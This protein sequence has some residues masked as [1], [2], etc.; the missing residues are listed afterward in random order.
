MTPERW[1]QVKD[2]FE[3]ATVLDSAQGSAYLDQACAGDPDLRHEVES[4]IASRERAGTQFLQTPAV[5]LLEPIPQDKVG[6]VARAGTRIGVYQL[7][8]EIGHGGMGEVYRARRA[9][10]Q[11]DKEV[12]VKVVRGGRNR[13]ALAERFLHERQIL[14]SLDHANIARLLD[15]GATA[16]GAP[17]LVMEFV[18][19]MPID[20]YCDEN[21]LNITQRLQL[22][23]Q[24]CAAVEYAHRHLVIHRDLKPGNILVTSQGN[25]KLLDFGIA[26]ILDTSASTEAT[27]AHPMTPGYASPEQM[28]GEPITT[29]T[30]IYSLGVV[31][32]HLLTGHSPYGA[33][34]SPAEL[35][36][37]I[38]ETQ[39]ERP[40]VAIL[41][42]FSGQV[43]GGGDETEIT[44]EAISRT[45]EG[46]PTKLQRRLSGDLDNILL[47]ALRKEP[48]RRY[49]SVE[50]FDEDLRRHLEG[51]PVTAR[52]DSWSYRGGKFINRH[53]IAAAA[54][55]VA[56]LAL[57]AGVGLILRAE[58][59]ARL[60]AE[61][62]QIQRSRADQRFNDLRKLSNSLIFEIHDAIQDLPGATPA[63]KL[64]LDRAVEYLDHLANNSNDDPD[65]QR[66]LA[67]GYQRLAV[68]QGNSTES[69]LG[70]ENS[71][72][73][74]DRK[75][76]ALFEAVA[77]AN[78]K[79]IIDQLNVAMGH[80]L[81]SF[82]L[83]MQPEGRHH[84]D[85]AMAISDGLIRIDP[86]NPKVR[87]ERAVE[88]QNLGI[89]QDIAGD[90]AKA[91]ESA[92]TFRDMRA[93]LFRT[94][95]DYPKVRRSVALSTVRLAEQLGLMGRRT[96]ALQEMNNGIG[97]YEQ[98]AKGDPNPDIKRELAISRSKL[99]RIQ[100][101]QGD[102]TAAAESFR[103]AADAINMLAKADPENSLFQY[104]K[105]GIDY[106]QGRALLLSGHG[107]AA[108]L[109]LKDSIREAE[110]LGPSEDLPIGNIYVWLGVAQVAAHDAAASLQSYKKASA[111]LEI[112]P[113]ESASD[114]SHCGSALSYNQLG[115]ALIRA[116]DPQQALAAYQKAVAI[117]TPL[118]APEHQDVPA[119]YAAADAY[120]GLGDVSLAQA[121]HASD[122]KIKDSLWNDARSN[123]QQSLDTWK[124][125]PNPSRVGPSGL[126]AGDPQEVARRR[127]ESV[128]ESSRVVT[129]HGASN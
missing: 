102:K 17:Y 124:R 40:S 41:K 70:D 114:D 8:E 56:L 57:V 58:R 4:L 83:L 94:N 66:E 86:G 119:F 52:Q 96:E 69:N 121:R 27:L 129:S 13:G 68:V 48:D 30:D 65:L 35:A 78:P 125:I 19:G 47:E 103:Q 3:K 34:R 22:F 29:S 97:I 21:N 85:Q 5:N 2:I 112:K 123:Y 107:V 104:D 49:A 93:D 51:L 117:V 106:E 28:R 79:N 46:S 44:P 91:L 31:L 108:L 24:V 111:L 64:L 26:K 127:D 77:K 6:Q 95:P 99:G 87:S 113:G 118:L 63:R 42:S 36:R 14:A 54:A 73:A 23:R 122:P 15:G 115:D 1:Q 100:L 43:D 92:R 116:G 81:L 71:A 25:L 53:K 98:L 11:Y 126:P 80:R 18:E 50:R 59:K 76:T 88:F 74:S 84:L 7:G 60:Q 38:T 62:A 90:R 67:W 120:Q 12:A 61:I 39:I 37:A 32:Y 72:V 75:A 109:K 82:M 110:A 9:D 55:G 10:G 45:R 16:D 128:R 105:A 33:T 101:M 89:M 20:Q